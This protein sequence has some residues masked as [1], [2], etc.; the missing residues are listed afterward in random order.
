MNNWNSDSFF[1]SFVL[2]VSPAARRLI[3]RFALINLCVCLPLAIWLSSGWV[4]LLL[5]CHVLSA[6]TCRRESHA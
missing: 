6:R 4:G 1:A 5:H 2:L 3:D